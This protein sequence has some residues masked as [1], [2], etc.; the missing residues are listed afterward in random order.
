M[1]IFLKR[2]GALVTPPVSED[3]LEGITRADVMPLARDELRLDVVERPSDRTE[4]YRAGE[5]FFNRKVHDRIGAPET[6]RRAPKRTASSSRDASSPRSPALMST[7]AV[8]VLGLLSVLLIAVAVSS[9]DWP[10]LHDS[11]IMLYL[12]FSMDRFGTVP[13]RDFFDMNTPGTY[14]ANLAIGRTFGYGDRA[15]RSADLL[16]LCLLLVVIGLMMK[17]F[18]W[19]VAWA[20]AVLFGLAYQARGPTIALQREY[21]ALL[22]VALGLLF[23]SSLP[24]LRTWFRAVLVGL[25]LGLAVVIKPQTAIAFPFVVAFL[26]MRARHGPD[27]GRGERSRPMA[28]VL[29]AVLGFIAPTAVTL[30]YLWHV[31]GLQPFLNIASGYWPLY[32]QIAGDFEVVTGSARIAY[33]AGRWSELGGRWPWLVPAALGLFVALSEKGVPWVERRFVMLLAALGLSFSVYPVFAGKFWDYHW[34]PFLFFL[35]LLSSLGLL[36]RRGARSRAHLALP[37]AVLLLVVLIG[38]RPP[39]AF[40]DRVLGRSPRFPEVERAEEIAGFLRTRLRPGET[41]QPLDWTGGVVHGMLAAEA[42]L[43]TRF[44]YDFHF[45]HHVSSDYTRDLKKQFMLALEASRPRFIIQTETMRPW[46]RGRDT[47]R[48]FD[49]LSRFIEDG[50]AT[51]HLGDGYVIYEREVGE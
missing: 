48:R 51:A 10:M 23:S 18:G 27:G 5:V 26:F 41:V 17:P 50:Y 20:S 21:L 29:P 38:V 25:L 47:S 46:V 36:E 3:I 24:R 34:L 32:G 35:I 22:P 7:L 30:G 9:L 12:A 44:V 37:V 45:Y 14:F 4:L 42:P 13:Y 2:H 31:G 1:S 28:V 6:T 15:L 11:P 16:Y 8:I 39:Y 33:L 49:E 43:A 40:R 19:K